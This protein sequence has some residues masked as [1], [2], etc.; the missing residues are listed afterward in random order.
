MVDDLCPGEQV[1]FAAMLAKPVTV[2]A[3]P[4]C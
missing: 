1:Y 4:G 3:V 2:H